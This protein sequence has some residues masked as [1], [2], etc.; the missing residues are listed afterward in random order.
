MAPFSINTWSPFRFKETTE[1]EFR[2]RFVELGVPLR[3][4][5]A[6]VAEARAE[7]AAVR[8]W[9]ADCEDTATS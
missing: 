9:L 7:V 1:L 3:I 4:G 8:A 6:D 2:Q 5:P